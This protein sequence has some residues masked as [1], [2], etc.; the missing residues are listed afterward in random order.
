M[1]FPEMMK[2]PDFWIFSKYH[3]SPK[4]YFNLPLTVFHSL[5][6]YAGLIRVRK[7][8]KK[9][10]F[11]VKSQKKSE[12]VRKWP[13]LV[14]KKSENDIFITKIYFIPTSETCY[15]WSVWM[16]ACNTMMK[17]LACGAIFIILQK[18]IKAKFASMFN[19]MCYSFDNFF[20]AS[21]LS[22]L[23]FGIF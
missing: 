6:C 19:H 4:S 16:Y 13:H 10:C 7:G 22:L 23:R 9:S 2:F 3:F 8:Q 14:S 17:F 12:K 11:F 5:I 18:L 20:Y 15:V 1:V 21:M